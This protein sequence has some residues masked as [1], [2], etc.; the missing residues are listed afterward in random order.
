MYTLL[1]I[2]TLFDDRQCF[3]CKRSRGLFRHVENSA[4]IYFPLVINILP[5]VVKAFFV[6]EVEGFSVRFNLIPFIT[7]SSA[8]KLLYCTH[9]LHRCQVYIG[10]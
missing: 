5:I 2:E 1:V 3:L 7:I 6:N 10:P 4:P 8:H 9:G